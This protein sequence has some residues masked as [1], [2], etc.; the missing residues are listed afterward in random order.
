[1]QDESWRKVVQKVANGKEL[2]AYQCELCHKTFLTP[3]QLTGIQ[4]SKK[5][6]RKF[7]N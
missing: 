2:E 7:E 5:T 4:M 6:V 1:M 3:A